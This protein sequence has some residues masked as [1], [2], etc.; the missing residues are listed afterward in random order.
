M[1]GAFETRGSHPT[2]GGR[3]PGN[4]DLPTVLHV[5]QPTEG[6]VAQCVQ[7]LVRAQVAAGWSV[8]LACPATGALAASAAAGGAWVRIWPARRSPGPSLGTEARCLAAILAEVRPALVHLHSS[9]A[10]LVGRAVL[11]GRLPVIFQPHAWS[12]EAAGVGLRGVTTAWERAA[13]RWADVTICVSE[14]ERLRGV[15][16][17]IGGP[18][19]VVPN[20]VD[21]AVHRIADE[22]EREVARRRL[23]LGPGPLAVCVG[24]LC[25]QKGQTVL[26]DAWRLVSAAL[27][28]A[29]LALVGG[30]PDFAELRSRAGAGVLLAGAVRDPRDWYAAADVVVCPS[31]WEGMALVPLEAMARG[32]SVVASDVTGMREAIPAGAGAL[33]PAGD[34]LALAA[35]V[36]ARLRRPGLADAEGRA[37]H[38]H[39]AR[40]HTVERAT[41]A[42]DRLYRRLLALPEVGPPTPAVAGVGQ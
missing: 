10:G 8:A 39:V 27:P 29:R 15:R 21:M 38:A 35:A 5:A 31:R 11:R 33:T 4:G 32:R 12:F 25:R 37:G 30:G 18:Y 24:R 22:R 42:V 28:A 3:G 36:T 7:D 26:L 19:A 2:T 17:G 41:L 20:G 16:A 40:H 13:H 34:V 1:A 23:G 14:T 6:G 9:K